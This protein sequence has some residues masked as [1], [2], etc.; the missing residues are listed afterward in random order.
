[1]SACLIFKLS[2]LVKV[3]AYCLQNFTIKEYLCPEI[4]F[5]VIILKNVMLIPIPIPCCLMYVCESIPSTVIPATTLWQMGRLARLVLP[6]L[7]ACFPA[8]GEICKI[9]C[10]WNL[11][12]VQGNMNMTES[13]IAT[14]LVSYQ[15]VSVLIYIN[16]IVLIHT[17][18]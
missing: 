5:F 12:L 8:T 11:Q 18:S 9:P 16:G 3:S 14:D 4:V 17:T 6:W 1:M 7:A 10:R 13:K 15:Q 2:F